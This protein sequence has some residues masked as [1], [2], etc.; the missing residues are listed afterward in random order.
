MIALTAA[1]LPRTTMAA[2]AMRHLRD[3]IV[4][5]ALPPGQPLPESRIGEQLGVSRAPVREALQL[6]EREGLVA[7]DRRGTARVCEFGPEDVRELGLMRLA[8]EPMAARLAC[9]R[10]AE[11]D[12][13]ALAAN[14]RALR[15]AKSLADVT[16]LDLE[17]HRLVVAA[18]GN[19][20]LLNAW[21]QLAAPFNVV[22]GQFH[23]AIEAR[24]RATRTNTLRSH[25]ELFETLKS[26]SPQENQEA[27][28]RH[29]SGW[30]Q[31]W[32]GAAPKSA[33][34]GG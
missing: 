4:A 32:D 18:S 24:T 7:F 21:E 9:K 16:Q 17:F 14:L 12:R 26:G 31:G 11:H 3:Q 8:L 28:F 1:P 34:S 2:S 25:L 10:L 15:S 29:A 30:L 20:R 13:D 27:A 5:G 33:V 22:M 6:L 23:R 19:R